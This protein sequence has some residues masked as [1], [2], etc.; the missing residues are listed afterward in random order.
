M[1]LLDPNYLFSLKPTISIQDRGHRA[2]EFIS[3]NIVECC[4]EKYYIDYGI[5]YRRI[6]DPMLL[7]GDLILK[8][9]FP[10]VG[11]TIGL[12]NLYHV[13]I[14]IYF[15]NETFDTPAGSTTYTGWYVFDYNKRAGP[16][17]KINTVREFL[18]G[19]LDRKLYI[20]NST[21]GHP[22]IGQNPLTDRPKED[23][24][25]IIRQ[26]LNTLE[27]YDP[28]FNCEHHAY[29]IKYTDFDGITETASCQ[30]HLISSIVCLPK[31]THIRNL[32][33]KIVSYDIGTTDKEGYE[34]DEKS[35]R[36]SFLLRINSNLVCTKKSNEGISFTKNVVNILNTFADY[37]THK[38]GYSDAA[39]N[40]NIRYSIKVSKKYKKLY[41]SAKVRIEHNSDITINCIAISKAFEDDGIHGVIV[42][43]KDV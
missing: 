8:C 28:V 24:I 19:S 42:K 7:F 41:S 40:I 14:L 6:S 35:N 27:S 29:K 2:Y 37:I 34:H 11:S 5:V 16:P 12:Y 20:L 33:R 25:S 15:N 22:L 36:S 26:K 21:I 10:P 43:S 4:G 9:Y 38:Q 18:D 1:S 13:G 23:I 32:K 31:K 3:N 30:Y 39:M 17:F